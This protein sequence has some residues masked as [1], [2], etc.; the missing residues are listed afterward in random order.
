MELRVTGCLDETEFNSN[1]QKASIVS[2]KIVQFV[3]VIFLMIHS[4][5]NLLPS[6][7]EALAKLQRVKER[8]ILYMLKIIT[9]L[10]HNKHNQ[11]ETVKTGL[12]QSFLA[13]FFP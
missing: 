9:I 5:N 10:L 8:R 12:S 7:V 4:F 1:L 6:S 2:S 3:P 13:I 11:A